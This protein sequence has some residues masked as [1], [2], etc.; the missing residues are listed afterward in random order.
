MCGSKLFVFA[1][2]GIACCASGQ[3]YRAIG[4]TIDQ[5]AFGN[6]LNTIQVLVGHGIGKINGLNAIAS[7]N[8]RFELRIS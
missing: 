5:H 8:S 4:D 6:N 7:P 2:V 1:E 3:T